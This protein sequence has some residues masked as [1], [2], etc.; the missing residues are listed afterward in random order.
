MTERLAREVEGIPV[1]DLPGGVRN[2]IVAAAVN[3]DK[4]QLL[5]DQPT[6]IVGRRSFEEIK[7]ELKARG[8]ILDGI[9]IEEEVRESLPP[10]PDG[11]GDPE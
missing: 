9:A 3:R 11:L 1:R 8:V 10:P 4:S 5:A 6:Q 2:V 7:R